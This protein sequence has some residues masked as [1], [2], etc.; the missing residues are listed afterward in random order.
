MNQW[1]SLVLIIVAGFL[2]Y[3][4]SQ[5]LAILFNWWRRR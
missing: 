1:A 3:H 2:G 5:L 4:T